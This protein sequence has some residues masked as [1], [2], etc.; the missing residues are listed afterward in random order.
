MLKQKF[1]VDEL[2]TER[3]WIFGY[4]LRTQ[5]KFDTQLVYTVKHKQKLWDSFS[6]SNTQFYIIEIDLPV[7]IKKDVT[8]F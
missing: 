5:D 2:T 7:Y 4:K 1:E 3:A 8:P 6:K